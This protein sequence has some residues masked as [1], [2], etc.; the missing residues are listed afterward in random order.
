M[1]IITRRGNI[2]RKCS[3]YLTKQVSSGALNKCQLKCI[4][5]H[6]KRLILFPH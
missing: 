2:V 4:K 3:V 1:N 6:I 5:I